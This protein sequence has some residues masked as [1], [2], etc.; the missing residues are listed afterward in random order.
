MRLRCVGSW[1]R[2]GRRCPH[3]RQDLAVVVR[4][5]G[6]VGILAVVRDQQD[7]PPRHPGDSRGTGRGPVLLGQPVQDPLGDHQL[8]SLGLDL[9]KL[10]GQ[11]L[12][13]RVQFTPS[14]RDPHSV[15]RCTSP[16]TDRKSGTAADAAEPDNASSDRSDDLHHGH[17]PPTSM[18]TPNPAH[19]RPVTCN[20]TMHSAQWLSV[21]SAFAR[22]TSV[23]SE[24]T[25]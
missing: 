25:I 21:P 17:R 6:L 22:A 15:S 19:T 20:F 8:L 13:E 11:F 7:S 18:S 4:Q 24:G 16:V 9:G 23:V 14:S 12:G 1:S 10:L 2:C 3:D 5:G